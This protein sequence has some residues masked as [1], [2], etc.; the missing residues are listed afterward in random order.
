[1]STK[2]DPNRPFCCNIGCYK[3][4]QS[5]GK[6]TN[7]YIYR[8]Y[9]SHCHLAGMGKHPHAK[10]VY[11]IKKT[12][13]ENI[14]GRLGFNCYTKGVMLPSAVLDLDHIDGDH[15][16]NVAENMQTLCKICHAL[17]TKANG[18]GTKPNKY[19][20]VALVQQTADIS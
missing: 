11:P 15:F 3:P 8:P 12:F 6:L 9:C 7:R 2:N 14:D 18:D 1:M 17:K 5:S 10:G 16:N 20:S 13:C 19:S 4:C